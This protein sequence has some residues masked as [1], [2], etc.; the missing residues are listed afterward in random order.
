MSSPVHD[1]SH[2]SLCVVVNPRCIVNHTRSVSRTTLDGGFPCLLFFDPLINYHD[3][4]DVAAKIRS[5]LNFE[6]VK[7]PW[8]EQEN[9]R[10]GP[11]NDNSMRMY[12]PEG[13]CVIS[14][15]L[16]FYP[17]TQLTSSILFDWTSSLPKQY[18]RHCGC[19]Y[20]AHIA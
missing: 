11:F 4:E 8:D 3:R 10:E 17:A 12:T 19:M 9:T 15:W 2:Y 7:R 20:S 13:K 16:K 5:W 6:W 1:D 14:F 18:V